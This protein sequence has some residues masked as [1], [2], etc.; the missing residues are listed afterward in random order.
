LLIVA[1]AGVSELHC[2]ALVRFCVLPSVYVPVAVNVCIVPSATE[3]IGGVT[4]IDISAAG[5]TVRVVDPVT[6]P[7]VA[8]TFAVPVSMLVATPCVPAALLIVATA[9]VSELHTTVPV[10]FCVLPSVN[11]PVAVNGS[12]VPSGTVGIAGVNA[13]ETKTA[14]VTVSVVDPMITP[15]VA[16]TVVLPTATVPTTPCAFTVAIALLAVPQV[17]VLLRFKVLPSL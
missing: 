9:G 16:V 4:A 17:T 6:D 8:E 11:V 2:T 12:V 13:I 10:M 1:T 15:D 3:G 5:L 7:L 14:G